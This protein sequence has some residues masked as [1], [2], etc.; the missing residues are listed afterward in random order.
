MKKFLAPLLT[1]GTMLAL[2]YTVYG[3]REQNEK[4]KNELNTIAPGFLEGGDIEKAKYID[5]LTNLID[6]LHDEVFISNNTLGRYE[7]SLQ[8]LEE[9]NPKAA[10]Q[11]NDF[12][13]N[14]TE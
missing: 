9:V 3:Y 11:F 14:E 4:L 1:A 6:S 13:T 8:N 2:L 7:I 10:K 12:L 5:S